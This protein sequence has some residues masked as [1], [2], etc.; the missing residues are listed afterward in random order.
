MH[1][2]PHYAPLHTSR[3][4]RQYASI[5]SLFSLR[6]IFF[7]TGDPVLLPLP[8]PPSPP[9]LLP[10]PRPP[11]PPVL[12]PP[13]QTK[14]DDSFRN[15][16]R[17]PE[18]PL[19]VVSARETREPRWCEVPLVTQNAHQH[20]QHRQ[21]PPA[22]PP[23]PSPP[24]P[25]QQQLQLVPIAVGADTVASRVDRGQKHIERG[26]T[27]SV[28]TDSR[29]CHIISILATLFGENAQKQ[30]LYSFG[31]V[32]RRSREEYLFYGN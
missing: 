14:A 15:K 27:Q 19:P 16:R 12:S 13:K 18:A 1:V 4:R 21:Q 31:F 7:F 6:D 20:Q 28:E 9:P 22:V 2:P 25:H 10:P 3:K 11:S 5:P 30:L 29:Y 24:P 23:S 17:E 26:D 8:P 32:G